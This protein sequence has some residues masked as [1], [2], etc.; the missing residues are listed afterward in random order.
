MK[1]FG[2]YELSEDQIALQESLRRVAR[3]KI[4]PRA[5]EIENTGLYP[6]DMF[7]LLRSLDLFTL[8]LPPEYGGCSSMLTACVVVEELNRVCYN[9]AYVL[10]NQWMPCLTLLA[11]AS[12]EQRQRYLP[13]L[14]KGTLRG[15]FSITEPQSGSDVSGIT[16]HA[17][18]VG[19]G[20][21]LNGAKV[22][23]TNANVADFILVA[24]KTLDADA[25][26]VGIN[27]YIVDAGAKGLV[28]GPPEKKFAGNAIASCPLFLDGV[29][30]PAENRLGPEGKMGFKL[31]MD[32]LA[33]A[34]PQVS[35]RAVGLAQGAIDHTVQYIKERRAFGQSISDF[36]GVRWMLADMQTRTE[37]ARQMMYRNAAMVD[38]GVGG[39]EL[40][41]I[42]SMAKCFCSD[43]AMAV[44]TDAV[45]LFG[46][47]GVSNDYPINRYFRTAKLIQ[48]VEG[49]NQ[50]Q[51][52]IIADCMLGKVQK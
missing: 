43:V 3:E 32:A 4:A 11:A 44:A 42:S 17:V 37:A 38:A 24:A 29:F 35:A 50:I 30:V 22:W 27:F 41:S 15:A 10:M 14:S 1:S 19:E 16:T 25:K 6:T 28:V 40:A 9:T 36:Q 45:Q 33:K 48:I 20:Y 51:R 39:L 12:E 18:R 5:L 46:A 7:E 23:C 2:Q 21:R 34:R 31:V 49:T 8:P 52:N 26:S 13:G 47:S